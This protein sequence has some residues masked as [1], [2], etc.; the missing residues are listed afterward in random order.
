VTDPSAHALT[1][2]SL[3]LR[4]VAATRAVDGQHAVDPGK[5]HF[6]AALAFEGDS[7]IID[8]T[9]TN[10]LVLRENPTGDWELQPFELSYA[11]H[12]SGAWTVSLGQMSF[13]PDPR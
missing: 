11:D 4:N 3:T 7:R 2:A 12:E 10:A 13:R 5:A 9:N 8:M 1:H 6:V